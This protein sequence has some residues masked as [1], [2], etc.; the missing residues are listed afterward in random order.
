MTD[1]AHLTSRQGEERL[2]QEINERIRYLERRRHR[3][4]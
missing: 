4:E 3:E 2:H 1:Q